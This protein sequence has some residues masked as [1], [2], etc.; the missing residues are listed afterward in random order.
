MK[1]LQCWEEKSR[2]Y[3]KQYG[4]VFR[5]EKARAVDEETKELL[6]AEDDDV[7]RVYKRKTR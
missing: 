1:G 7:P 4:A 3:F 2:I 5:V 6:L